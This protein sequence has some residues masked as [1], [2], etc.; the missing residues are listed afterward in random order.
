MI[1]D[2]S[3]GSVYLFIYK[4]NSWKDFGRKYEYK[5]VYTPKRAHQPTTLQIVQKRAHS[6]HC[7]M[8]ILEN[9]FLL[10]IAHGEEIG[11]E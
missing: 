1:Y 8:G 10:N 7:S 4:V 2:D 3:C 9:V 11:M 6:S 5:L